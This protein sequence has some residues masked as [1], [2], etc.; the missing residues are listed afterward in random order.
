MPT[1]AENLNATKHAY[2]FAAWR[3]SYHNGL[4]QYTPEN[5]DAAQRIFDTLIADL[6][7]CGEQASEKQ[8]VALFQQAIEATNELPEDMIETGEREQLCELTN[9]ITLACGLQPE[10]YGDGEGLASEWREW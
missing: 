10:K 9:T 4:E 2:T 5:C 1:Y 8:K 3:A 6:I 7:A